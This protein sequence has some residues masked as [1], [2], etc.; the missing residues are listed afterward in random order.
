MLRGNNGK[1]DLG[2]IK[3]NICP[4]E[5]KEPNI[6]KECIEVCLK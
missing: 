4:N 6:E 2:L 1:L 3:T 5:K